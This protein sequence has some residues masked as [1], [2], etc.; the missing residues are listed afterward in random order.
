MYQRSK[1]PWGPWVWSF[2]SLN[3]LNDSGSKQTQSQQL[4]GGL[5]RPRELVCSLC[6][7]PA[8]VP[9]VQRH[10]PPPLASRAVHTS[11]GG[12]PLRPAF[13]GCHCH[14][15]PPENHRS[16]HPV[17]SLA[18]ERWPPVRRFQAQQDTEGGTWECRENGPFWVLS[19]R[20]GQRA[21]WLQPARWG[22][23]QCPSAG[24]PVSFFPSAGPTGGHEIR[25][26]LPKMLY[27]QQVD[28]P[29]AA[30][31]AL[32][33]TKG[34]HA[35]GPDAGEQ[36]HTCRVTALGCDLSC[37]HSPGWGTQWGPTAGHL[38]R[39]SRFPCRHPPHSETE[40]GQVP[41]ELRVSAAAHAAPHR[42][43]SH[44]RFIIL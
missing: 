24:T 5:G 29:R 14:A 21:P 10:P 13:L 40:A 44:L 38:A 27:G 2:I 3:C 37:A 11:G 17:P 22:L 28:I 16:F 32:R 9:G 20:G 33:E 23:T 15:T 26:K 39:E 42:Q 31:L 12:S 34:R 36:A 43:A 6:R 1:D 30:T 25:C 8:P 19:H 7:Q 4:P 35:L 41:S 18:E